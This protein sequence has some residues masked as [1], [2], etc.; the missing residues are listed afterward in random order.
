MLADTLLVSGRPALKYGIPTHA[1]PGAQGNTDL[2]ET[3]V[4][5]GSWII[6]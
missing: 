5:Q 3:S 4:R 6:F 2:F 1:S